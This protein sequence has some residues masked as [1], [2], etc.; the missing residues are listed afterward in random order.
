MVTPGKASLCPGRVLHRRNAP[1]THEFTRPVSMVWIDPDRPDELFGRH[2]LWS[3]HRPAPVR[4][5]ASD[6]G[7]A[8]PRDELEAVLGHRPNGPLRMLTQPRRWGWLFN[9]FTLHLVW[10]APDADPVGAVIE[11]SNTPWKERHRY[12]LALDR[13]GDQMVAS[14]DKELHVSPFL[15]MDHRYDLRISGLADHLLVDLDVVGRDG[16]AVVETR[17]DVT[18]VEPTPPAMRTFMTRNP[19]ATHRVSAGIHLEAAKLWL[20]RVPFVTHPSTPSPRP[21]V[22]EIVDNAAH[23]PTGSTNR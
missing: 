15:G 22:H 18:Q 17:L 19:V 4:F 7:D 21:D 16:Q 23:E 1:A 14:F 6:H 9:P 11:V 3:S 10:D 8:D 13:R 2:P 20:K 12:P 5:R